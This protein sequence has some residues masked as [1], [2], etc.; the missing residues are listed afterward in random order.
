M[1]DTYYYSLS[2]DLQYF[3]EDKTEEPTGK[4]IEDTRKKGQVGKSQEFAHGIQ[5]VFAFLMLRMFSSFMGERFIGVIDWVYGKEIVD[6]VHLERGGLTVQTMSVILM[7]AFLQMLII[8]APFFAGGFLVALL[9]TG[10]QFKFKVTIE[11]LK[12][13]FDK[14]NPINGFKRIFSPQSLINLG[15]SLVKII[16]ISLVVYSVVKDRMNEIY[17]LYDISL[18]SAVAE[19]G[20]LVIDIGFRISLILVLVG[21]VDLIYHKWKFKKDIKMTK[22]EV[23]DEYKNAEGDPQIKGKQKQKMREAAM[24]RMMREVPQ[25]DVVI[26]NPTHVAVAIRY[27]AEEDVAPTVVGKG[28]EYLAERI[29]NIARDN[30]IPIMENKPLARAIFNTVEVG[31]MIPPEL[32]E[33]VAMILAAVWK[34]AGKI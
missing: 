22:Q 23:K 9:S 3:A 29:K 13:K 18:N 1:E 19:I 10:L 15:L 24:R 26:T 5:L 32:Y 34:A 25:A 16:I 12:P 6:I 17:L 27:R 8:V 28:E 11:P 30:N 21:I 4:K 20:S 2:Y 33:G 31:D 14:F 7:Q